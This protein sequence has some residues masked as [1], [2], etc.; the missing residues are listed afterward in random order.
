MSEVD[1]KQF[2]PQPADAINKPAEHSVESTTGG[3]PW[4]QF[5]PQPADDIHGAPKAMVDRLSHGTAIGNANGDTAQDTSWHAVWDE[6][7]KGMNAVYDTDKLA[8]SYKDQRDEMAKNGFT[9]HLWDVLQKDYEAVQTFSSA[10][11]GVLSGAE[12]GG[13]AAINKI[14]GKRVLDPFDVQEFADT[15]YG[16]GIPSINSLALQAATFKAP[17]LILGREGQ[18]AR[19]TVNP[20]NG[21]LGAKPVGG[22]PKFQ[23]FVE[24]AQRIA[25]DSPPDVQQRVQQRLQDLWHD[26]GRHPN[27]VVDAASDSTSVK[28]DLSAASSPPSLPLADRVKGFLK[29]TD[30][31]FFG[32]RNEHIADKLEMND[33]LKEMGPQDAERM[34]RLYAYGEGDPLASLE[35]G[36]KEFWEKH[37]KPLQDEQTSLFQRLSKTFQDA[38][39]EELAPIMHRMVK[40]KTPEVDQWT[41]AASTQAGLPQ[42]GPHAGAGLLSRTTSSLKAARYY[43]AENTETGQRHLVQMSND[44][45]SVK[46]AKGGTAPGLEINWEQPIKVGDELPIGDQNFKIDRPYTREI[47]EAT[48]TRYHKNA[49]ASLMDN[50][51]HLRAVDRAT[52]TLQA[53]KNTPEWEEITRTQYDPQHPEFESPKMPLFKNFFMD[54]KLAHIIDD[55]WGDR[56]KN[57]IT[58]SLEKINRFAI[59]SLFWTPFPHIANHTGFWASERGWDWLKPLAYKDLAVTTAQALKSVVTQDKMYQ[60]VMRSGASLQY[61]PLATK[62]FMQDMLKRTGEQIEKQDG[63]KGWETLAGQIG[64]AP[65]D[66]VKGFYN[67]MNSVLW[68]AG[69]VMKVQRIME[70][71]KQ[72]LT[73]ARAIGEVDKFTPAYRFPHEIAGDRN[74]ARIYGSNQLFEFS[75]YHWDIMKYYGNMVKDLAVGNADQRIRAS[76]A[77]FA[78][79]GMQLAVWPAINALWTT[80]VNE[81]QRVPSFGP[82]RLTEPLWAL[83]V[84]ESGIQFP[85]FVKD[86]Y[87]DNNKTMMSAIRALVPISPEAQIAW[88]ALSGQYAHNGRTIV[89]P[90]DWAEGRY[91]RVAGQVG[92]F[93]AGTLN[94]PYKVFSD[95][96]KHGEDASSVLLEQMFGMQNNS[97]DKQAAVARSERY[98][99][100]AARLRARK[101]TGFIEGFMGEQE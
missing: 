73:R 58:D 50:V 41:G 37:L 88:G 11:H 48:P 85:K 26:Y 30:N 74:L 45:M 101:P 22:L 4:A 68:M 56:E 94:E 39:P 78:L 35:H 95:A 66:L 89:E 38:D 59:N 63:G 62:N 21:A 84:N 49:A 72:G 9:G 92:D 1:W 67:S 5:S 53:L 90:D 52:Y 82:G 98:N 93:A 29:E 54:P 28:H 25:P 32:L 27:E 87:S 61:G 23:D 57:A 83:L 8:A 43:V 10:A 80:Y 51:L 24:A 14:V 15:P 60:D 81:E 33:R 34:K 40:G 7:K 18:L 46:G 12:R 96:W 6:A 71:E 31:R 86:Y 20:D 91:N 97:P 47:E 99:Q 76:G 44:R 100:R 17:S 65:V 42:D 2:N 75:R 16:P 3:D 64:M 79:A 77:L 19:V 13:A 70:L 69:D 55:F 36:D